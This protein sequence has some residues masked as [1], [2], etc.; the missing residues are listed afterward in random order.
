MMKQH[1][2][3]LIVSSVVTLLPILAGLILWNRLPNQM[4]THW[5]L[6]GSVD[7]WSGKAFAVFGLPLILLAVH[8]LCVWGTSLDSG[9]RGQNRKVSG[10][11]LWIIPVLSWFTS[12]IMYAAALNLDVNFV[13][14]TLLLIG[15]MFVVIG[16]YLPKCKQNHTIGIRIP[17]T[18][19]DEE[20]WNATHR[21]GGRI[22]VA[23]GVLLLVG[24]ALPER[25]A[26][27][28]MLVL[29]LL[30]AA[31][32]ILYSWCYHK[33]QA[34]EGHVPTVS[35]EK[36]P[37]GRKAKI[38]STAGL[39]AV[40]VLVA[41]LMFTGDI[42]I[43][44]DEDSFTVEADYYQDLTVE[45]AAVDSIEYRET[46][47]AGVRTFGFGSARLLMGQFK[48]D[49][50]GTHTRYSYTQCDACVVITAGEKILVLSGKDADSTRALYEEL[51]GRV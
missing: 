28:L 18:L 36:K 6:D 31:A 4:P 19:N 35:G 23:G 43:R 9:N 1:K 16:N 30:L 50:F 29:I 14:V 47:K 27:T 24:C 42:E 49:A 38:I 37:L 48:N 25:L 2:G 11:V 33:K 26:V 22:W 12:G 20:N 10:L 8:W 15:I 5:G 41:V 7:G 21:V 46:D 32:P 3:K 40:L 13:T 34:R 45:Y 44:C 39:V 51:S 17:W